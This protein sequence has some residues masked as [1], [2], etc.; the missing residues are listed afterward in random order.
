M[1]TLFRLCFG[2]REF[3]PFFHFFT[4]K[5]L[6]MLECLRDYGPSAE[7]IKMGATIGGLLA[8]SMAT[9]RGK[10][11]AGGKRFGVGGGE[12]RRAKQGVY[13][14]RRE[15]LRQQIPLVGAMSECAVRRLLEI[16]S[17]YFVFFVV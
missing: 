9:F 5:K 11:G 16:E 3:R 6:V 4:F 2:R 1:V 13:I 7:R 15:P 10:R 17:S 8:K 12:A 14:R